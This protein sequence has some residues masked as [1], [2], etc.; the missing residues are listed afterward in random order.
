M[1]SIKTKSR[2]SSLLVSVVLVICSM[3]IAQAQPNKQIDVS[4]SSG[5]SV[6][7]ANLVDTQEG[8]FLNFSLKNKTGDNLNR[9]II[10]VIGYDEN[11]EAFISS[12][13][14]V[15]VNLADNA[16]AQPSVKVFDHLRNAQSYKIEVSPVSDE[17]LVG[18]GCCST[19]TDDA[20][21][22][23]GPGKVKSTSC[24]SSVGPDGQVTCNCDYECGPRTGGGGGIVPIKP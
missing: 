3:T 16:K 11:G 14:T 10:K 7:K 20:I 15:S 2:F 6:K 4:P 22:A 19:C 18:E 9:V 17:M 23:C 12:R 21:R 8:F 1:K 13:R 24:S 5:V